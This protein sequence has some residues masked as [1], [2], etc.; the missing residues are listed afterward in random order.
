MGRVCTAIFVALVAFAIGLTAACDSQGGIDSSDETGKDAGAIATDVDVVYEYVTLEGAAAAPN[1][2]TGTRTEDNTIG[3]LR[4][5]QDTG[6]DPPRAV[7]AILLLSPGH[8]LGAGAFRH[9]AGEMVKMAG[10]EIEVWSQERRT[11]FLEDNYGMDLA[12]ER[13]DARLAWDY[14]I[15]GNE[16]EGRT[17]EG[18]LSPRGDQT[19]MMSE[20]G[21]DLELADIHRL[22][23]LVPEENRKTNLFLGGHSRG[24]AFVQAYAAN[25][26]PDGH[27]GTEDVAG[28]VLI[29]GGWRDKGPETEDEYAETLTKL[30]TGRKNRYLA[31]PGGTVGAGLY[32]QI[33]ILA[34]AAADGLS[35]PDDPELGPQGIFPYDTAIHKVFRLVNRFHDITATNEVVMASIIASSTGPIPAFS[36]QLG[37]PTG[38]PLVEGLGGRLV[39]VDPDAVY[40]WIRSD[41]EDPPGASD[42]QAFYHGLYEGPSNSFDRYYSMRWDDD[43][44]VAW[45]NVYETK[46]TW[47]ESY[48]DMD[49]AA[50]DAPVFALATRML[51]GMD[52]FDTYRDHLGPVRGGGGFSRHE[53]GFTLMVREDWGHLDPILL[54]REANDFY[55]ALIEWM[56]DNAEGKVQVPKM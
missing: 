48:F 11:H 44:A 4:V 43:L 31:I 27:R 41:E 42:I 47:R 10:G 25:R 26:F 52:Q 28:L 1:P 49:T 37:E 12:E 46:G 17:F 35:D 21:L 6:D 34:M 13:G 40:S 29:D 51:A 39:M 23:S 38:G 3:F 7:H 55:P 50:I 16:V 9:L 53:A 36:A 2:I 8:T 32:A 14:Y 22:I 54:R 20:W 5:R 19:D 24:V 30:R 45:N 15:E 18:F 33:E 56:D